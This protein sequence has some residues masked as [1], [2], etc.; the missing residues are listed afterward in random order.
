MKIELI[1]RSDGFSFKSIALRTVNGTSN[2]SL[3]IVAHSIT[4]VAL[5]RIL[6][7]LASIDV[8]NRAGR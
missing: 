8:G 5:Y 3:G 2:C 4:T 1:T 6:P 7:K